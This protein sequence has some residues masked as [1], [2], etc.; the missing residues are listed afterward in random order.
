MDPSEKLLTAAEEFLEGWSHF[1]ECIDFGRS[2]L[3][4]QAI[5]FMNEVPGKIEQAVIEIRTK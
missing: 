5:A 4:A 1:C 3:D 2:N